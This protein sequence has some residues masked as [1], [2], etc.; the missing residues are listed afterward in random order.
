MD[1]LALFKAPPPVACHAVQ[2]SMTNEAG[3]EQINR[4]T[5]TR[6]FSA[7]DDEEAAFLAREIARRKNVAKKDEEW[8]PAHLFAIAHEVKL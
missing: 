7:N 2:I 4:C 6:S 5:I 3:E 8:K 1:Y